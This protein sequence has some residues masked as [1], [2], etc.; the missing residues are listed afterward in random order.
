MKE[1]TLNKHRDTYKDSA[2]RRQ[3][4]N[5]DLEKHTKT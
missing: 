2:K 3:H 4:I 1:K 5:N